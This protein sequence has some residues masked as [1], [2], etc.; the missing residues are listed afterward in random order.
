M[1]GVQLFDLDNWIYLYLKQA[2][3]NEPARLLG[4]S[5]G[6]LQSTLGQGPIL[7]QAPILDSTAPHSLHAAALTDVHRHDI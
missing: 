2:T 3:T 4:D 1:N 7:Q 5:A 6:H